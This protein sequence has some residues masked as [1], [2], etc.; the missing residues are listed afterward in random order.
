VGGT[1]K[2][3]TIAMLVPSPCRPSSRVQMGDVSSAASQ[4]RGL[5]PRS[6]EYVFAQLASL[7]ESGW[8][9][10]LTVEMLEIYN[11]A[12]GGQWAGDHHS[13]APPSNASVPSPFLHIAAG[14]A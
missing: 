9:A 4:Q 11:E 10:R 1:T 14:A 3:T 12:S 2:F 5:I 6:V 13:L 7:S 8:S